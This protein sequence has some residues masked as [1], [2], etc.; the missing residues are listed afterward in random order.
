MVILHLHLFCL[1]SYYLWSTDNEQPLQEGYQVVKR[2]SKVTPKEGWSQ[3]WK[4]NICLC[5]Q[6][7]YKIP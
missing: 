1:Y 5:T 2:I 3:S 4:V 7:L 6:L